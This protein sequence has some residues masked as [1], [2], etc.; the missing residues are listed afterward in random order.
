MKL[1][2]TPHTTASLQVSVVDPAKERLKKMKDR[3]R[4][5]M[6]KLEKD[7][8]TEAR[9]KSLKR[10]EALGGD[11]HAVEDGDA[12][13]DSG[14][15]LEELLEDEIDDL[16]EVVDSYATVSDTEHEKKQRLAALRQ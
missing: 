8:R 14:L 7:V 5:H 6:D 3:Y 16:D 15:A 9:P 4:P 12:P 2:L 10:T 1:P 11:A 13:P